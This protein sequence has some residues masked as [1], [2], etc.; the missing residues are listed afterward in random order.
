MSAVNRGDSY[1]LEAPAMVA[2]VMD[3]WIALGAR[4]PIVPYGKPKLG[5]ARG[6]NRLGEPRTPQKDARRACTNRS[7][8][9][10]HRA[11]YGLDLEYEKEAREVWS[12]L[13]SIHSSR[14]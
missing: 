12:F 9:R 10:S 11:L 5:P 1:V 2:A 7:H 6:L 14:N 13:F 4:I 3:R 8:E